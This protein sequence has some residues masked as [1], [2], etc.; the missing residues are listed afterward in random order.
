MV[1]VMVVEDEQPIREI[2]VEIL[3]DEGYRIL[4]AETADEALPLL[5]RDGVRLLVTDINLPGV[6]DGIELAKAAREHSPR[7][8]V[9]FISGRSNKLK[10][11]EVVDPP[12]AFLQKPFRIERLLAEVQFLLP[13]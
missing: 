11:A 12:V 3:V 5:Q 4:E 10:D 13:N 2:L 7:I 6:L 9:V 8:P 1:C